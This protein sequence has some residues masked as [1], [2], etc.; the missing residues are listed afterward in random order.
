VTVQHREEPLGGRQLVD[1][2]REDV[3]VVVV[4]LVLVE[5]V[6]DARAV[7][8]EVFDGDPVI[9]QGQVGTEQRTGRRLQRERTLLHEAH[10]RQRGRALR[11]AGGGEERV[12]RVGDAEATVRQ[13]VRPLHD[14][15]AIHVDANHTGHAHVRGDP[16]DQLGELSGVGASTAR[17][18]SDSGGHH[19]DTSPFRAACLSRARWRRY[20]LVR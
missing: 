3:V 8:Q 12:D 20:W 19:V 14:E 9:D 6:T 2:H 4:Q 11:A 7:G 18:A 13:P 15:R 1:R 10:H 17:I 5:V 16:V